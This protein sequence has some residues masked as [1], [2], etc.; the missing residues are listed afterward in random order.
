MKKLLKD[1]N[2]T[3]FFNANP[4]VGF[5]FTGREVIDIEDFILEDKEVRELM[6]QHGL[7]FYMHA[8]EIEMNFQK[9]ISGSN[10]NN[11]N[12]VSLRNV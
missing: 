7:Q 8:G 9:N 5:D 11:E 3:C 4:I 2:Y 12:E 1:S 10:N 6:L